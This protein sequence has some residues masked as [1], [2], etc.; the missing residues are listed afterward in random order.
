MRFKSF[1]YLVFSGDICMEM[2]NVQKFSGRAED[3]TAGR[4][5]YPLQLIDYLYQNY[6]NETYK[7]TASNTNL[8]PKSIDFNAQLYS[9]IYR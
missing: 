9:C 4:P 1:I 2:E 5:A 8:P 7:R 6:I 3:Y